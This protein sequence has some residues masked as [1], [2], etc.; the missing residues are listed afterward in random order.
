MTDEQ[1][2]A[3]FRSVESALVEIGADAA[4]VL[5]AFKEAFD[6][7][8]G[9]LEVPDDPRAREVLNAELAAARAELIAAS[10]AARALDERERALM[11]PLGPDPDPRA[12]AAHRVEFKALGAERQ[13]QRDRI[14]VLKAVIREFE[15]ALRSVRT[16]P[17]RS[18]GDR[19]TV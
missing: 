3:R 9:P 1:R 6:A 12:F 19:G 18:E 7:L 14:A 4:Q 5:A 15:D 17:A 8:P 11:E 10:G 13:K 16:P 2:S